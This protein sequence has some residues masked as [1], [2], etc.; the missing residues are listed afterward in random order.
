MG[1]RPRFLSWSSATRHAL[2]TLT[3]RRP[4]VKWSGADESGPQLWR[5]PG[6]VLIVLVLVLV[7]V[8]DLSGFRQA[9]IEDEHENEDEDD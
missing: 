9:G 7:V 8:L 6:F 5:Q 4:E 1:Q 2:P 3:N